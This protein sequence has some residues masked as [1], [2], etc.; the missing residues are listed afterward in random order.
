VSRWEGVEVFTQVVASGTFSKAAEVLGVSKSHISRQVSQLEERLGAQLLIRTTRKVTTTEMGQAFYLRCK[1]ILAGLDEAENAVLD[2]QEAPT[3][4][5]R[6]TVAGAFGERYVAPAAVDFMLQ[7]PRLTVDI[8]FTNRTVDLVADGYDLAIRAGALK[9]SSMIAR[10]IATRTLT[11]CASRDYIDRY[12][13]PESIVALKKHNCLLG[14]N[15]TWRFREQGHHHSEIRVDGNWRSNNGYALLAAARKGLGI[16]QLPEFYVREDIEQGRLIQL[17]VN[18]QPTDTAVWAVY[19][20]N[21]HLSAKVRLFV[22][23]LVERFA[24]LDNL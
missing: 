15:P 3:G 4:T 21:R 8:T 17:L 18:T 1:D 12:G 6:M 11:I 10:R 19:P 23:F 2:L 9:D 14:T 13:K 7:Y 22:A 24:M 16:V 5:L 20:S